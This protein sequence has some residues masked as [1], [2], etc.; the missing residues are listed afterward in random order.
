MNEPVV[1]LL[2]DE[3]PAT[4]PPRATR[5]CHRADVLVAALGFVGFCGLVLSHATALLEPDD[6]AYRASI[7]ALSQGHVLLSNAQFQALASFL[8]KHG[9]RGIAQWHHLASGQWI[10]E[11]NPGYPFFA[12]LFYM[13]K[14]LRL[15]PLFYGALACVGLYLGARAWLGRWAGAYAV[16]V[17]CFSGAALVFAWRATIPT[18]TD[19]SLIAAG[20]GALLWTALETNAPTRRRLLVGLLSF[21]ALEGAVF[22]RYTDVVELAVALIAVIVY[23]R[24][25]RFSAAMMW[26]WLGS[27]ALF[28]AVDLAYNAWAYGSPTSTGYDPGEIT[29]SFSAFWPNLKL[30]PAQLSSS[31]PVWTLAAI[32]VIWIATRWV[33]SR[34]TTSSTQGDSRRDVAVALVLVVGWLGM[35]IFYSTYTWTAQ[36]AGRGPVGVSDTVH[37][38]RFYLPALGLLA[39]LAAWLLTKLTAILSGGVLFALVLASLFSFY[40][41]AGSGIAEGRPSRYPPG[42]VPANGPAGLHPGPPSGPAGYSRAPRGDLAPLPAT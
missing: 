8:A 30:M 22:I 40:A 14:V 2:T 37:L 34:A 29:F 39:L 15:A 36:M 41:M 32:A 7:V 9:E 6:Y 13:A 23:Y 21:L 19:A 38:I 18:F 3:N 28:G 31:M 20:A 4:T 11:K 1:P 35:W 25:A 10:S 33:R 24:R 26:T 17:Y 42:G 27:V 16:W 12:V 5:W